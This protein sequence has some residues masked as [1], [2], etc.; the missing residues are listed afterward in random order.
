MKWSVWINGS[1]RLGCSNHKV[2]LET[3]PVSP[4]PFALLG[5]NSKIKRDRRDSPDS[6]RLFSTIALVTLNTVWSPPI[7]PL[8]RRICR[9]NTCPE[10]G[11]GVGAHGIIIPCPSV[12]PSHNVMRLNIIRNQS[13]PGLSINQSIWGLDYRNP[14][15]FLPPL[16]SEVRRRIWV[17]S[18]EKWITVNWNLLPW[19]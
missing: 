16:R 17:I 8:T 1:E 19:C 6:P 18:W 2:S 10:L 11:W 15:S 9:S 13:A 5:S 4:A 3:V 14:F 12:H 7:S